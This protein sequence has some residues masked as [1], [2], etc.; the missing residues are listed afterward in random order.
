MFASPVQSTGSTTW[1]K[2]KVRINVD[3]TMVGEEMQYVVGLG[4][5][6]YYSHYAAWKSWQFLFT[7]VYSNGSTGNKNFKTQLYE[8]SGVLEM[9]KE[10]GTSWLTVTEYDA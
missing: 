6:G 5:S 7:G 8:D 9:N 2:G 4:H 3:G 1:G 10:A